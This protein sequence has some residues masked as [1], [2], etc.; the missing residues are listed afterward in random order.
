MRKPT[1][2]TDTMK[3]VKYRVGNNMRFMIPVEHERD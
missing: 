1:R 2:G 3:V